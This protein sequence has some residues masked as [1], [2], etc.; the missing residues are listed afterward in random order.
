[1]VS[2]V[3][4]ARGNERL[5]RY[6]RRLREGYGY[7]LRRVEERSEILGSLIDNSQLSRFEKGKAAPSFDKL[8]VL[9][10]VFNV[11]VQTFADVLDLQAYDAHKPSGED[12]ESLFE[13]G[14]TAHQQGD[15]GRAYM[16][17]E[18]LAEISEGR[19][20]AAEENHARACYQMAIALKK[21]GKLAAAE[22]DLRRLLRRPEGTYPGSLRVRVM[23]QL[24]FV[25]RELGDLYLASVVARDCQNRALEGADPDTVAAALNTAGII[26]EERARPREAAALF[27]RALDILREQPAADIMRVT[28][29]ANLGGALTA[30]GQFRSGVALLR[31]AVR[32]ARASGWRRVAALGLTKMAE[33]HV[34]RGLGDLA[35]ELIRESDA[36]AGSGDPAYQDLLFMNAWLAYGMARADNRTTQARLL[37]GRLKY[38]RSQLETRFPEV[39]AFDALV[40]GE[41][42]RG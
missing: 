5:G 14:T 1:M 10:R 2:V 21:M 3:D 32:H 7:T 18:R 38:L 28:V 16:I 30:S 26:E 8:R 19:G 27:R 34:R 41:G 6:I 9:A 29:Q 15:F 11:P 25:Y 33:A 17:F 12:P 39:E 20:A 35:R 23:L 31:E 36:M 22:C 42:F 40:R 37:F 13:A 4:E 24:A